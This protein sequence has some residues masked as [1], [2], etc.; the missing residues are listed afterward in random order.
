MDSILKTVE[1]LQRTPLPHLLIILGGLF[2]LLAFVGKIGAVIEMPPTRQKWAGLVG[3][4][5]LAMGIVLSSLTKPESKSGSS[6]LPPPASTGTAENRTAETSTKPN[7]PPSSDAVFPKFEA[8]V[9]IENMVYRI[10]WMEPDHSAPGRISLLF[11]IRV[12]EKGGSSDE[13]VL[14]TSFRLLVDGVPREPNL[15]PSFIEA[16]APN[17]AKDGMIKFTVPSTVTDLK[18]QVIRRNNMR[19]IPIDLKKIQP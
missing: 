10:L 14:P 17:S 8:E 6:P 15:H 2:L 7:K 3:V 11:G 5:F 18:L 16:M 9:N 19:L 13:S 4:L 1:G 12:T